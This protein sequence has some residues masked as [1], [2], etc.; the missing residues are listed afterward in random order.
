MEG[1]LIK[2]LISG[3]KEEIEEAA[4]SSSVLL[5]EKSVGRKYRL[6]VDNMQTGVE[7]F[8][9]W[10]LRTLKEY[11]CD[12][13][14]K[15]RDLY[16]ATESSALFGNIEARK[17]QQ[18]Q[19]AS[20]YLRGINELTQALFPMVREI[21]QIDERID[22]Y[23]QSEDSHSAEVALKTIWVE[24]V[25]GGTQNP[26]SVLGLSQAGGPGYVTLADNFFAIDIKKGEDLDKVIKGSELNERVKGILSNKLKQYYVWK[27]NTHK[28]TI[29]RKK[30]MIKALKNH[31]H[32]LRLYIS[33]LKPYLKSI[34]GL[35]LE[36]AA[37]NT[38]AAKDAEAIT[39]KIE[40]EILG[41]KKKDFKRYFPVVMVKIKYVAIPQMS[42]QEEYQ[43][44]AIHAGRS[45]IEISGHIFEKGDIENYM[46]LQDQEDLE[47]LASLTE[48]I[49][50][51]EEDIKKY[52]IEAGE[53]FPEKK[54]EEEKKEG[55]L[56]PFKALASS[57]KDIFA[58]LELI[59]PGEKKEEG[60]P[61]NARKEKKMA[62]KE[63][64][65]LPEALYNS[66]KKSQGML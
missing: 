31:Y 60:G 25:E 54:G 62:E 66:F 9:F 12:E 13:V 39:S 38:K 56:E 14:L 21:K 41:V 27:A 44:G 20:N 11:F 55:I 42:F 19:Q 6:V 18:Q 5:D 50:V 37:N 49:N 35:S 52:L 51:L 58:F 3:K 59:K 23:G 29:I 32:T 2:S 16:G 61:V 45:E 22:L 36:K 64:K 8:Y 47:I 65:A 30:F 33:W 40:L 7:K 28:E 43:R 17:A 34:K 10:F 24:K 1:S 15:V 26:S 63:I 48:G 53:E 57:F 46:K 4:E